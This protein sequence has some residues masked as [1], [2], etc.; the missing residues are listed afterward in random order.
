MD[1]TAIGL[2]ARE[3]GDEHE[4]SIET[5]QRQIRLRWSV[6]IGGNKHQG[7]AVVPRHEHQ[8]LRR[9]VQRA[10]W[11]VRDWREEA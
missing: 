10:I 1:Y 3:L 9:A 2:L 11:M 6:V 4:I 8:Q 5:T 7:E